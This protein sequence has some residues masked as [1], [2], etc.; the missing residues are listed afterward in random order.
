[1]TLGTSYQR[2]EHESARPDWNRYQVLSVLLYTHSIEPAKPL[3]LRP[4]GKV[5][6][7]GGFRQ[8]RGSS[9]NVVI[10]PHPAV[11]FSLVGGRFISTFELEKQ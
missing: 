4:L 6:A 9:L 10:E 2:P 1:M 11:L 8:R 5:S 3:V 7:M